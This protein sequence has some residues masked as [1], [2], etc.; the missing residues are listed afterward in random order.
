M[1]R[2]LPKR[3]LIGNSSRYPG[4]SLIAVKVKKVRLSKDAGLRLNRIDNTSVV[5]VN[6]EYKEEEDAACKELDC[7]LAGKGVEHGHGR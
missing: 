2:T 5:E 6:I 1:E 4:W 7:S 3:P